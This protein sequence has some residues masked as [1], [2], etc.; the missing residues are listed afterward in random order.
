MELLSKLNVSPLMNRSQSSI[1]HIFQRTFTNALRSCE[2]SKLWGSLSVLNPHSFP[3]SRESSWMMTAKTF[4]LWWIS[5]KLTWVLYWTV[6]KSLSSLRNTPNISYTICFVLS[7]SCTQQI[8]FIGTS[9]LLIF[10]STI[11]A[12]LGF[13]IL[14]WPGLCHKM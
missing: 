5:Y 10:S 11:S 1:S 9:S 12:R 4:S 6:F 14:E 8:L 13:Q 3:I 2:K 7:T